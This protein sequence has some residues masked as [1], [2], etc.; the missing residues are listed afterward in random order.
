MVYTLR[1]GKPVQFAAHSIPEPWTV[2][3]KIACGSLARRVVR[4]LVMAVPPLVDRFLPWGGCLFADGRCTRFGSGSATRLFSFSYPGIILLMNGQ[5]ARLAF[6][7][8]THTR[9][10]A[11]EFRLAASSD[12]YYYGHPKTN[13]EK[14]PVGG[15]DVSNPV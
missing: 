8:D 4:S 7:E 12:Q 9:C 6:D 14:M 1:E 11:L 15:H 2:V 13:A 3:M 10:W 5:T